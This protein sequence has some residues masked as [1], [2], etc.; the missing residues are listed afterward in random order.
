MKLTTINLPH[1]TLRLV[2]EVLEKAG[3]KLGT[4]GGGYAQMEL[5]GVLTDE[6]RRELTAEI[7]EIAIE[8]FEE[9]VEDDEDDE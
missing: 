4:V 8:F 7:A 5:V 9:E 1:K 2:G 6:Q 3:F